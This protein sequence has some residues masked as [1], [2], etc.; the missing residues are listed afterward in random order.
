MLSEETCE[1]ATCSTA[2]LFAS[3]IALSRACA[4]SLFTTAAKPSISTVC[5]SCPAAAIAG[6]ATEKRRAE[7]TII[8]F[9]FVDLRRSRTVRRD[10]NA[11]FGQK[12]LVLG[13]ELRRFVFRN[14]HVGGNGADAG[15]FDHQRI[16]ADAR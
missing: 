15:R 11:T 14:D 3:S 13:G 1:P 6:S 2:F 9:I 4:M 10:H 16:C 7:V 5:G 8:L 12:V